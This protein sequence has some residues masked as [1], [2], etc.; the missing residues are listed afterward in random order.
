[1]S[2]DP[3]KPQE[4]QA[5]IDITAPHKKE[6]E[7]LATELAALQTKEAKALAD[8]NALYENIT[9]ARKNKTSVFGSLVEK[10]K[11]KYDEN[12]EKRMRNAAIIQSL[13][14]VLTAAVKGVHAY[15][16][17]GA[18][19]VPKG[20]PSNAMEGVAKI[21]EMQQKYLKERKA[22]D[23]LVLKWEQ[24]KAD[25]D[26]EAAKALAERGEKNYEDIVAQRKAMQKRKQDVDDKI[27]DIE[28]EIEK[29]KLKSQA[30]LDL[31]Q[32]KFDYE[33]KHPSYRT[34]GGGVGG[35]TPEPTYDLGRI[36][37]GFNPQYYDSGIK[38]SFDALSAGEKESYEEAAEESNEMALLGELVREG[39]SQDEA[40][41]LIFEYKKKA[42]PSSEDPLG[43]LMYDYINTYGGTGLKDIMEEDIEVAKNYYLR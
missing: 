18:G 15:G 38:K 11:P 20:A 41:S 33:R 27:R 14:D 42:N 31:W 37:Y 10:R 30:A 7:S 39:M 34:R 21:N 24:Q 12:K 9:T 19:V 32:K 29:D 6:S 17:R 40:I 22:W 1:M 26:V 25:D 36:L 35:K 16:K 43:Q 8:A 4:Q 5:P 3:T 2:N 13:G 23:D 28:V